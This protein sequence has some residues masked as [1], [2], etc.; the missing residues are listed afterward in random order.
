MPRKVR[1]LKSDLR[2]IGFS[3]N[4]VGGKGSHSK[5]THPL[6]PGLTLTLSGN[7]GDDAQSYQERE[8]RKATLRLQEV[9]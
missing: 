2:K 4:R 7:D 1:Q 6:L 9:S 5:W 8:L 3:E